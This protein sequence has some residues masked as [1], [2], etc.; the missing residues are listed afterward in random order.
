[1]RSSLRFTLPRSGRKHSKL[2]GD[3]SH[4]DCILPLINSFWQIFGN[5][6]TPHSLEVG[7]SRSCGACSLLPPAQFQNKV[8]WV[9]ASR[10]KRTLE[11]KISNSISNLTTTGASGNQSQ[12][13]RD[14]AKGNLKYPHRPCATIIFNAWR[15]GSPHAVRPT[16]R[17]RL[18]L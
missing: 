8:T 5:R 6:Q 14:T 3:H 17:T 18:S 1:M 15:S 12:S 13:Q 11:F 9:L 16:S 2:T 4:S 7:N 10:T